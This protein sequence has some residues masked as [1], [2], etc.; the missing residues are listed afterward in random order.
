MGGSMSR[1]MKWILIVMLGVPAITEAQTYNYFSPGCALSGNATSQ[2][3]NLATGACIIGNLPVTNLNGGTGASATTYWS[4]NG[5]WSTPTTGAG[6]STTQVQ[7]NNAGALAGYAN[8][9]YATASN[10]LNV[11]TST[12]T[13]NGYIVVGGNNTG[14]GQIQGGAQFTVKGN[15][16]ILS[17]FGGGAMSLAGSAGSGTG[18][19]TTISITAGNDGTSATAPGGAVT[20]TGGQ[21]NAAQ[22]SGAVSLVGGPGYST[23]GTAGAVS[24]QGGVG[25]TQALS[26]AVT[27][28]TNNTTRATVSNAGNVTVNAPASGVAVTVNGSAATNAMTVVSGSTPT[29]SVGDLVVTRA[30]STANTVGQGANLYLSDSTNNTSTIMQNSGGQT[31]L[32]QFNGSW[33]QIFKVGTSRNFIIDASASGSTMQINGIAGAI[34]TAQALTVA[35][36]NTTGQ[37]NGIR[38]VAGTNSSDSQ[39]VLTNA[40]NSVNDWTFYGDGGLTSSTQSDK[41][42]GTINAAGLY[43]NGVSVSTA[44]ASGANPSASVGLNAVNGSAATFMRSDAAPPLSTTISPTMTGNWTFDS[45]SGV[46]VTVIGNAGS[47][48]SAQAMTIE[49]P[50]VT[51]QSNGPRILAGTNSSDTQLVLT[52][53]ADSI[54]DWIFYGNG[55]ATSNG[56]TNQGAGTLNA[57][58]LYVNGVSVATGGPY[59]P[60]AG[61]TVMTGASGGAKGSGTIN[62]TGLYVNGVSVATGTSSVKLAT[63]TMA[64]PSTVNSCVGCG[65]GPSLTRYAVGSYTLYFGS[66]ITWTTA[67]YVCSLSSTGGSYNGY[68]LYANTST[69][70]AGYANLVITNSSGTV[71]DPTTPATCM[72][73]YQ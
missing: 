10:T 13:T 73:Q 5:T 11:G 68:N 26:G 40:A 46:A 16:L 39:L 50:N 15:P 6:G 57:A 8:F 63:A 20:I 47:A 29:Q 51:G 49:S 54:N 2:V 45:S 30:G 7:V 48:F 38:I 34:Y 62:A 28:A 52:N 32:W 31:E 66:G 37:S 67:G 42:F 14:T 56:Q 61:N 36:P 9:T 1:M 69:S 53:A 21:G 55:G 24:I 22:P 27:I 19:G 44:S 25:N 3:V 60:V 33:N 59:V 64:F 72:V 35:S 12:S 18:T 70:G 23:T 43:V 17:T 41:G 4:G 58:G 65:S 71:S